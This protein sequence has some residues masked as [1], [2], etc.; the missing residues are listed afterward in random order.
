MD[1]LPRGTVTFLA[2]DIQGSTEMWERY[3]DAMP[4]ALER[5]EHLLREAVETRGGRVFKNVGDGLFIAFSACPPAVDAALSAQRS[6]VGEEWPTP[7]PV[8]VRMALHSGHAEERAGD[9][10][11]PPV[12]RVA[13]I[14]SA[15]YG[16]QILLSQIV[17][18]LVADHLPTGAAMRDLGNRSLKDLTEPERIFQLVTPDLPSEF[19]PLNTLDARPHNLPA[20]PTP[21]VGRTR[22]IQA[23]RDLLLRPDVRLVSL[24]GSAGTGKTRLGLQV[25]AEVVDAFR[26]GVFHVDMAVVHRADQAP[27]AILKA[28]AIQPEGDA[29]EALKTHLRSRETLLV[30]DNFEQVLEAAPLV[31]DLLRTAGSLTMLVTSQ[32]A[33]KVRGEHEYPVSPLSIPGPRGPHS[34]ERLADSEAVTL[35][36]ERAQ[37][38]VPSFRLEPANADAVAEIVRQLDGLPLAIELAAARLKLFPPRVMVGR[39]AQRFDFLK[40]GRRDLPDRQR[41]LRSALEWSYNL[42]DE[43]ERAILRRLAVFDGGF[44]FGAAAEVC[45]GEGEDID[46]EEVIISLVDKSLLRPVTGE[47][48]EPRFTRLRTI[49]D[50]SLDQ[51]EESGETDIWRRRHAEYFAVLAE[52][53]DTTRTEHPGG[54]ETMVRIEREYENMRAALAWSLDRNETELAL[55]LCRLPGLWLLGGQFAEMRHLVDRLPSLPFESDVQRADAINMAGRFAQ[56]LGDNSPEVV[57]RFEEALALYRAAGHQAGTARALMNLG[58][59][60]AREGAYEEARRLFREAL[61]LYRELG[62]VFGESGA[63][64]NLGETYLSEDDLDPAEEIF[65]EA[66]STAQAKGNPMAMSFALQFMGAVSYQRGDLDEA[67]ARFREALAVFEA[68]GARPGIAWTWY[69]LAMIARDRGN[70]AEAR[71]HFLDVVEWF[72]END[73][74]PGIAVALLGLATLEFREGRP[75]TAVQLLGI[76]RALRRGTRMTREAAEE[77]AEREV[78]EGGRESLGEAGYERALEE[79]ERLSLERALE[80]VGGEGAL[81]IDPAINR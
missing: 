21:I 55:R 14:L 76:S 45:R 67:E 30:L 44:T 52:K 15:G 9:Y 66:R 25:A 32:A 42:L 46:V 58:N 69:Y 2:T 10:F 48:G 34:I 13:R 28:L 63:L 8:R 16:G 41:T 79:G 19:P 78:E 17:E 7:A 1:E 47:D 11:G 20:Q 60:R 74:R 59:V 68:F 49:R 22:E 29:V 37:A 24:L 18:R 43:D 81:A 27:E 4:R 39:L 3:P 6:L 72:R 38:V 33:L 80:I 64:M 56:L 61:P 51:L 40:G 12:N 50:F 53:V 5:H 31:A 26:D 35:F 75:E 71:S 65:Q 36:T 23:V 57:S 73:Y 54:P 77:M 70:I 62:D